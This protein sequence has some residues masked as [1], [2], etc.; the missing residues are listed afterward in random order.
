MPQAQLDAPQVLKNG[1]PL[2]LVG[3]KLAYRM[4]HLG[5]LLQSAVGKVQSGAV[6]ASGDELVQNL[7]LSGCRSDGGDG[8]GLSNGG[9][10]PW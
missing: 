4:D 7:R 3:G 6:H 9:P 8:L 1:N 5:M 10:P 2:A